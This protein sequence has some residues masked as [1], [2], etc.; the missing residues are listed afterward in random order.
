MRDAGC[1]MR[2]AG[3]GMRDAGCG[4][5]D[6]GCGMRDAGCGN[7]PVGGLD[8]VLVLEDFETVLMASATPL[9]VAVLKFVANSL[10]REHENE[11][12]M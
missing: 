12:D 9:F 8:I 7:Y 11:D 10:H 1:G 6:A 4:M 2:D 3:C 5:R